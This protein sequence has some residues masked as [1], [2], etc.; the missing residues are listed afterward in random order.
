MDT[1]QNFLHTHRDV[2]GA[3]DIGDVAHV[4]C[5]ARKAVLGSHVGDHV[6]GLVHFDHG[7]V[8]DV[9]LLDWVCAKSERE[10][11]QKT[12]RKLLEK[13]SLP[14]RASCGQEI[15]AKVSPAWHRVSQSSAKC[16]E[17]KR[18]RLLRNNDNARR[19]FLLDRGARGSN[20]RL[21]SARS[22]TKERFATS[23]A[24]LL[25]YYRRDWFRGRWNPFTRGV[26][27][28]RGQRGPW[29]ASLARKAG[30]NAVF[31]R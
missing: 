25:A 20:R 23:N 5:Q 6:I 21:G 9:D 26:T 4:R 2:I 13:V 15:S 3:P 16:C 19:I 30:G 10:Q 12:R 27:C 18:A 29:P 14:S 31:E 28:E 17:A 22:E 1:S 11:S 8:V 24:R 7:G